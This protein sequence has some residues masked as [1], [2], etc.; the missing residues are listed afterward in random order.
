MPSDASTAVNASSTGS[1]AATSAPKAASRMISVIGIVS[2]SALAKS[3]LKRL[4]SS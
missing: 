4:P 1:P 3:L 2:R